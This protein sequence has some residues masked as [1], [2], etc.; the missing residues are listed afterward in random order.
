[1]KQQHGAALLNSAEL[2]TPMQMIPPKLFASAAAVLFSEFQKYYQICERC[3][4][5][6]VS[7]SAQQ[8]VRCCSRMEGPST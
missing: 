8:Q 6:H 2:G 7:N 5:S 4:A 3:T 1:M